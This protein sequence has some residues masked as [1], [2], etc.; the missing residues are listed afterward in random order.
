MS[1]NKAGVFASLCAEEVAPSAQLTGKFDM[2]KEIWV[3]AGDG[4]YAGLTTVPT[5]TYTVVGTGTPPYTDDYGYP[6]GDV[7]PDSWD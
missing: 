5:Y 2:E 6:D 4:P 7:D 3:G 1:S